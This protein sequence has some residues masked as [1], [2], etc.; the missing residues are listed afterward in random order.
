METPAALPA[1]QAHVIGAAVCKRDVFR[2]AGGVCLIPHMNCIDM[3]HGAAGAT[4]E[5]DA[6]TA[7]AVVPINE[8]LRDR[9]A[10]GVIDVDAVLGPCN[11][12]VIDNG[13][14]AQR[15]V[16][17]MIRLNQLPARKGTG[18]DEKARAGAP[19]AGNLPI[20]ISA[21]P[22]SALWKTSRLGLHS[23]FTLP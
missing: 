1:C 2:F 23:V 17:R 6:I 8:T 12:T 14:I 7:G 22:A 19:I 21:H 15:S 11:F 20:R 18:P 3:V 5:D 4:L 10:I 16:R 9:P 13:E